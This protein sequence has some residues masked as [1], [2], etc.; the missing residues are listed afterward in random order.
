[1]W[2]ILYVI[3]SLTAFNWNA[4]VAGWQI[5]S[6]YYIDHVTKLVSLTPVFIYTV[7]RGF[8]IPFKRGVPITVLIPFRFLFLA[9]VGLILDSIKITT[10]LLPRD[11]VTNLDT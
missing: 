9:G 11:E 7:L 1:M 4:I 3:A 8:Y 5:D 2:L 6:P 10:I